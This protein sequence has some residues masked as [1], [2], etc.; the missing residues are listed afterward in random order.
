M[1]KII[2][3]NQAA[4]LLHMSVANINYYIKKGM[5]KLKRIGAVVYIEG[6]PIKVPESM[7]K[8]RTFFIEEVIKE[9][10]NKR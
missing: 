1:T 3:K 5:P 7:G 8:D 4:K 2:N 9:W 6:E 10:I